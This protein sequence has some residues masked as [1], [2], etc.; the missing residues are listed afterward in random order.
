LYQR[1]HIAQAARPLG[2]PQVA[3]TLTGVDARRNSGDNG[4]SALSGRASE[5]AHAI[6]KT[7]A[8]KDIGLVACF[9]VDPLAE[10]SRRKGMRAVRC[11]V[12]DG[13]VG[14]S[15]EQIISAADRS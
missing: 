11:K 5:I 2:V 7:I 6:A 4:R 13:A 9:L 1:P 3:G 8:D 10:V 15:T 12:D 14:R